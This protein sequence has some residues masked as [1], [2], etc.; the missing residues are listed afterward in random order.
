MER[1]PLE[2]TFLD[3]LLSDRRPTRCDGF[4]TRV[5]A[6]LDWHDLAA[7]LAGI[8]KDSP[9]GGRPHEAVVCYVKCLLLAKWF[10]LSDEALE[11]HLL[12]RISFR[13]FLGL[14]MSDKVPDAE[15][16]GDFRRALLALGL[17]SELFT[18][19][20]AQLE[21]LGL[22]LQE[23]TLVDAT[24]IEAPLGTKRPDGT[25]TA[26]PCAT[27]TSKRGRTYFGYKGHIATDKRGMV[28][29]YVYDTARVHDSRHGDQLMAAEE[30][31]V[32]ADSA[33]MDAR[34]SAAL[35]GRGVKDGIVVRRVRGQKE[36]TAEQKAHNRLVAGVR[37][38]VEHPFAWMAKMGFGRARYRGLAR[39]ALDF[40]L[41]CIGYNIKRAVSLA[42][43]LKLGAPV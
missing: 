8:F 17:L 14:S 40:G 34:R 35:Q 21:R 28:R 39:N 16:V 24:I 43:P 22:I 9:K 7:P 30:R 33:Y 19:V 27:F 36:L 15:A 42:S 37:A 20:N 38:A 11:D 31:E 13:Q 26:D 12:D 6:L 10:N 32:Y 3:A 2:P 1:R 18:R 23:G 4:F 25:S 5:N 29:D 41:E